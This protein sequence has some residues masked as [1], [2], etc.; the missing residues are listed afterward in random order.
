MGTEDILKGEYMLINTTCA[1]V[2][3][4]N[5]D[6]VQEGRLI[7]TNYKLLFTK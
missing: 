5:N 1:L 7:I 2:N 4:V 6:I 3:R